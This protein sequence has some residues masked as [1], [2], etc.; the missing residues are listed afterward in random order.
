MA[1]AVIFGTSEFYGIA[2]IPAFA[3]ELKVTD[4]VMYRYDDNSNLVGKYSGWAKKGGVSRRY[5]DGKPYTGWL[6]NKDG[7][8]KY[9]LDGYLVKGNFPI[10]NNVCTFDENGIFTEKTPANITVT[11]D[12][13]VYAGGDDIILLAKAVRKGSYNMYDAEK[14]ERWEYGEW[15]DCLGKDVEYVT[16]D[17]LY[18]LD[19]EY[20]DFMLIFE[21]ERYTGASITA[22]YYR[23]TF[24]TDDSGIDVYAIIRVDNKITY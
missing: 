17:S 6:K 5:A 20:I 19:P 13:N 15:V 23:I 21:P 3:D 24:P 8:Y 18:V 11:Q 22:G 10:K 14:F 4:G 1:A 16:A 12:G 2:E 7:S 9:C